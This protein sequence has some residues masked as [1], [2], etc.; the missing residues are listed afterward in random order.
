MIL[1]CKLRQISFIQ[2]N[3]N[4]LGVA[5]KNIDVHQGIGYKMAVV[6]SN[7]NDEIELL[8]VQCKRGH[9]TGGDYIG[10]VEIMRG[11]LNKVVVENKLLKQEIM[12]LKAKLMENQQILQETMS[13]SSVKFF[14]CFVLFEIF[15]HLFAV[16]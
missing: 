16:V 8:N 14:F 3:D 6:M 12:R 7:I 10:D 13:N 9:N 15:S 4:D 5:F 1:D 11:E 2:N